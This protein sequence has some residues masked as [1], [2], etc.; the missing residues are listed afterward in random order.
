M[1]MI[2]QYFESPLVVSSNDP[3][4]GFSYF[5]D[6]PA[7]RKSERARERKAQKGGCGD[8]GISALVSKCRRCYLPGKLI[9]YAFTIGT[10]DKSRATLALKI[11]LC[12]F[13]QFCHKFIFY[14][15]SQI[16]L[17]LSSIKFRVPLAAKSPYNS[18]LNFI[19]ACPISVLIQH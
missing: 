4:S 17:L 8:G 7:N 14:S 9:N 19:S 15:M 2:I 11:S 10:R 5:A 18:S 1:A 13:I 6:A 16:N 12:R 3:S